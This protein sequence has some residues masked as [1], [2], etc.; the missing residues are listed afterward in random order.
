MVVVTNHLEGSRPW[1][2]LPR[3][4]RAIVST[5]KNRE[6]LRALAAR[7]GDASAQRFYQ[8]PPETRAFIVS[9]LVANGVRAAAMKMGRP[10]PII[11]ERELDYRDDGNIVVDLS[12][13]PDLNP[14][15]RL[16]RRCRAA[17]IR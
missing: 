12:K 11:F 10:P 1:A 7:A 16:Y 8:Q 17:A 13:I 2:K 9:R 15:P 5:I 6:R 3:I 14:D 4:W